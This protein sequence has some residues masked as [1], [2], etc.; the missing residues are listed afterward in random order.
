M[1]D[2]HKRIPRSL[3]TMWPVMRSSNQQETPSQGGKQELSP[4]VDVFCYVSHSRHTNMHIYRHRRTYTMINRKRCIENK[5][6]ETNPF[7]RQKLPIHS[8]MIQPFPNP[9][10]RCSYEEKN[11]NNNNNNNKNPTNLLEI[12][13]NT[14]CQSFH[15][16]EKKKKKSVTPGPNA[17]PA[18][19]K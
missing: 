3:Q 5:M 15:T 11:N 16:G 13:G 1:G 17:S 9:T 14:L 19:S 10:Q 8:G 18:R 6:A 4:Q 7:F 12:E 2:G